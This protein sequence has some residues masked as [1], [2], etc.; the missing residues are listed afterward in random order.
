[1]VN[2]R[3]A[4]DCRKVG[5][6][7][8]IP[9]GTANPLM[10]FWE[11]DLNRCREQHMP[12]VRLY[13]AWH[14]YPLD[15]PEFVKLLRKATEFGM[16]I[17]IALRL[18]DERTQNPLL[19]LQPADPAPL[20]EIIAAIPRLRLVLLNHFGIVK[21]EFLRK[22]IAAGQV[23][24]DIATVESVGGVAKLLET[25]PAERVLFGSHFPFFYFESAELK[26]KESNLEPAI[27][28]AIR[29]DNAKRLLA[30]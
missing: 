28:K 30:L 18:E 23:F 20:P 22:L 27:E 9:F 16:L 4:E 12:G 6:D 14:G 13:P 10:P 19:R 8:L 1:G 3:L 21:P 2:A 17:Q 7:F 25:M 15:H 5:K 11:D 26:L 29:S 24:V